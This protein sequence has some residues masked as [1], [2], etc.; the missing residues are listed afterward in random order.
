M[1]KEANPI[2]ESKTEEKVKVMS[3]WSVGGKQRLTN[4]KN[5][6]QEQNWRRKSEM[7][8]EGEGMMMMSRV[9]YCSLSDCF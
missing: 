1:S 4:D 9:V 8:R 2:L 3:S 6:E 7:Y 5:G